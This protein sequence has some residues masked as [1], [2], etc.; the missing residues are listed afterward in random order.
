MK[1][2]R[3]LI[4]A[5]VAS[6]SFPFV[7]A[8]LVVAQPRP[9]EDYIPRLGDIM[10]A[11]QTR[12]VKVWYAGK[13]ANWELAEFELRQLKAN[14]VEAALLYAGIPVNNV[15]TM[16]GPMQSVGDAIEARDNK[17]FSKTFSELTAACNGCHISMAR[18]FIVIHE[19]TE[20]QPLGDQIFSPRSK[21]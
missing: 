9:N 18:S 4:G 11:I 21:P 13:A 12:H 5:L 3:K 15:M 8:S 16:A 10:S 6:L 20:K 7:I 1:R 14:L 2:R 17:R 19:P